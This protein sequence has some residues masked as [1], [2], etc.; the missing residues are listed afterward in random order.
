MSDATEMV[1]RCAIR[2]GCNRLPWQE[3]QVAEEPSNVTVP[4]H[5]IVRDLTG[6]PS[7]PWRTA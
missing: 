7:N 1:V 4:L 3:G 6:E 5:V 2:Q